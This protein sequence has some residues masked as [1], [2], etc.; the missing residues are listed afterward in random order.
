MKRL[1]TAAFGLA[2]VLAQGQHHAVSGRL[3]LYGP[4]GVGPASS[5]RVSLATATD[6]V[7]PAVTDKDGTFVLSGV[8]PGE[9]ILLVWAEVQN[10]S[11]A[12]QVNLL[13]VRQ[14]R[15]PLP[16][17]SAP[18]AEPLRFRVNVGPE[19]VSGLKPILINRFRFRE[20]PADTNVR[21]DKDLA[22]R[23]T[24]SF[25]ASAPIWVL[26]L[27]DDGKYLLQDSRLSLAA[28][29]SWE[30]EGIRLDRR[31]VALAAVLMTAA[32]DEALRSRLQAGTRPL[33]ADLPPDARVIARRGIKVE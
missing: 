4:Q 29:S 2:V 17:R 28:D 27:R 23:G 26:P 8:R 32:A 12:V 13:Q 20:P 11:E 10:T 24:H 14:Q 9:H 1:A 30:R 31:T 16:A 19:P 21:A 22:A 33:V 25:P 15:I 7:G 5:V 6:T 3:E 18:S